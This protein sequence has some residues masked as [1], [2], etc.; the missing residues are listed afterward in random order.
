VSIIVIII[1]LLRQWAA[2]HTEETQCIKH[3]FFI[4]IYFIKY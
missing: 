3:I 4:R 2:S 1:H